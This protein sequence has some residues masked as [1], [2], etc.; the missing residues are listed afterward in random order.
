MSGILVKIRGMSG[1]KSCHGKLPKNFPKNFV[2][3]LLSISPLVPYVKYCMLFLL[4][5]A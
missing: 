3:R 4:N 5:V 1:K 2:S